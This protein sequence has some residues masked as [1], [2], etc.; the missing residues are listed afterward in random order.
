M[1]PREYLEQADS[2][3]G[4]AAEETSKEDIALAL[5]FA[6]TLA[7]A[8]VLAQAIADSENMGQINATAQAARTEL[9]RRSAGQSR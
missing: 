5:A 9:L 3:L 4:Q 6:N 8:G 2:W 1:T 7:Q